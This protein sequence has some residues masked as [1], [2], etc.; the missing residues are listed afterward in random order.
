MIEENSNNRFWYL[1]KRTI[2]KELIRIKEE[3]LSINEDKRLAEIGLLIISRIYQGE[4]HIL[5][6]SR[7]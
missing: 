7:N 6:V 3:D 1:G 5:Y 2:E 4:A